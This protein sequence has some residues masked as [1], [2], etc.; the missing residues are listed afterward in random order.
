MS[1]ENIDVNKIGNYK[2]VFHD[3][4]DIHVWTGCG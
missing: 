4:C 2:Y 3:P 1:G